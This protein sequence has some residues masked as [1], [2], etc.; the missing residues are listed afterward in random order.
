M[1]T[2]KSV[3]NMLDMVPPS[4]EQAEIFELNSEATSI[5]FEANRLKSYEVSESHGLA[6]RLMVDRRLGFAATSDLDAQDRLIQNALESA[7]YGDV[8]PM[9]F[10]TVQLGSSVRVFDDKLASLPAQQLVEMGRQAVETLREAEPEGQVDVRLERRVRHSSVHNSIGNATANDSAPLTISV[11]MQ[12]VRQDDVLMMG[13]YYNT[14]LWDDEYGSMLDRLAAKVRLAKVLTSLPSKRMPVLFAPGGAIVLL[15]PLTQGLNGKNVYRGVSPMGG[16]IGEQLFDAS[17]SLVDDPTLDGRPGSAAY[18]DEGVARRRRSLIEQG[19][20][21]GFI[22]DLKTEALAGAE[23][24]GNGE[25]SLFSPPAP[26]FSNLVVQA[27]DKSLADILA[28]IDEGLL[29]EDALGI[30]QGNVLSG[31]FTNPLSLAFKIEHG[32]IAGRV[33]DVSIAGN[34]YEELKHI[35]AISREREWVYGGMSLPYILLPELNVVT[36]AG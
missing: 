31:A 3:A 23:P 9:R 19:T 5:R 14:A 21:K 1:D 6:L 34:I 30:G 16:R 24:T 28:G 33:K 22:Y 8:V 2:Q 17:F 36:K 29:V 11:E 26:E 27:G 12:R 15:L 18:D 7:R 13:D 20:L 35:A 32:K 25:R 10:P 4:A